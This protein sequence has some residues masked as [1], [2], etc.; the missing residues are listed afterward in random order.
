MDQASCE[1]LPFLV[2]RVV[3]KRENSGWV[4]GG[5]EEK[6]DSISADSRSIHTPRKIG[7]WLCYY[8]LEIELSD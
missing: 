4:F 8:N 3:L 1:D 7:E 2:G 6:R 5:E